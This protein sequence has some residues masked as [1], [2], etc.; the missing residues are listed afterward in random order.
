MDQGGHDQGGWDSDYILKREPA[1]YA[2]GSDLGNERSC[3]TLVFVLRNWGER[4]RE[5]QDLESGKGRNQVSSG[6][7]RLEMPAGCPCGWGRRGQ[8]AP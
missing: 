8:A 6:C 3:V 2:F 7:I 4:L 1:E 5:K